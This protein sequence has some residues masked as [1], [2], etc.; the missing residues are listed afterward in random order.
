M[1][2]LFCS[3]KMC[4]RTSLFLMTPRRCY[5]WMLTGSVLSALT[6]LP[7]LHVQLRRD[8]LCCS[9]II[10]LH[11]SC[12]SLSEPVPVVYF[13]FLEQVTSSVRHKKRG[14]EMKWDKSRIK[15]WVCWWWWWWWGYAKATWCCWSAMGAWG[16][17]HSC[18]EK[19]SFLMGPSQTRASNQQFWL[20]AAYA[21]L[22]L[23]HFKGEPSL[24]G[25]ATLAL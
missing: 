11:P 6:S 22:S 20:W 5:W 12:T 24:K 7:L 14:T 4:R 8:K 9:W 10:F 2:N 16:T 25:Q 23:L 15:Q 1:P 18:R 3:C 19:P 13:G 21:A 17:I